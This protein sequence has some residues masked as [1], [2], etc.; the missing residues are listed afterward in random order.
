MANNL[1][2]HQIKCVEEDGHILIIA[3]AGSGKTT[4]LS[5][6]SQRL[7]QE[8][9]GSTLMAVTFTRDAA[10]ELKGRILKRVPDANERVGAG[11]FHSLALDQ[12]KRSGI[13]R[14][15]LSEQESLEFI[16]SAMSNYEHEGADPYEVAKMF[17]AAQ[18]MANPD[19]YPVF[20]TNPYYKSVWEDYRALKDE[21]ALMDFGDMLHLAV[22]GMRN[23]TVQ[24][25]RASYILGDEAQD[26][27]EI[28][29]EWIML[30][31]MNGSIITL[32]ADDDQS[33]YAFRNASGYEGLVTFVDRLQAK[34]MMLPINY[35]CGHE[36]LA[37]GR[38]LIENNKKRL[39]KPIEAGVEF[40][41]E[42]LK[43]V[44]APFSK[45]TDTYK[46]HRELEVVVSNIIT[47]HHRNGGFQE[48]AILSRDNFS[49]SYLE[50]FLNEQRIIYHRDVGSVWDS[51]AGRIFLSLLRYLSDND[52]LEIATFLNN[53]ITSKFLFQ[54]IRT[55]NLT[56]LY[57]LES[58]KNENK[59]LAKKNCDVL[60]DLIYQERQWRTMLD[61]KRIDE[62]INGV[63]DFFVAN[64]R[65]FFRNDKSYSA[66]RDILGICVQL[67]S[68]RNENSLSRRLFMETSP[69]V[70]KTDQRKAK[71]DTA[72]R[73][74]KLFVSLNTMH[75]S[76]GLEFDNV[77]IVGCDDDALLKPNE[78]GMLDVEEER[79]LMYVAITRARKKLGFSA[80]CDNGEVISTFL[81]EI[82][83]DRGLL[84]E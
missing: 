55:M 72:K 70:K 47:D 41:G 36:I 79:R 65:A 22:E 8:Q 23:G 78:A 50:R 5:H 77:Y 45:E 35:R 19:S 75:S 68:R 62:V 9:P 32:V 29:H 21:S 12:L 38:T 71:M 56:E 46:R 73:D 84:Y 60:K 61:E 16:K 15:I 63:A 2:I 51:R 42:V 44:F 34:K 11:T 49:L 26:M 14:K 6:R 37:L 39:D 10:N 48:W 3:G 54:N 27:D 76:K 52:W 7:L 74:G 53:F 33:I 24:P 28:Q 67:L 58:E 25:F 43:P 1:N 18:S 13:K 59:N 30:H 80:S 83:L 64:L 4:V 66:A 69:L 40:P 20:L 31:A 82:G 57:R 17:A 81:T